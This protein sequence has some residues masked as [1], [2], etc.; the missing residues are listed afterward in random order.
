MNA[1]PF[2]SLHVC[3]TLSVVSRCLPLSAGSLKTQLISVRTT[4]F[5]L[6]VCK[7]RCPFLWLPMTTQVKWI[8][9]EGNKYG[10]IWPWQIQLK[11]RKVCRIWKS[12]FLV[13]LCFLIWHVRHRISFGSGYCPLYP[14]KTAFISKD[15]TI[16]V[17][18]LFV[19]D[20]FCLCASDSKVG[21]VCGKSIINTAQKLSKNY[22]K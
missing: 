7:L 14:T 3:M 17:Q 12:T 10:P 6:K 2:S 18:Y 11:L 5:L 21:D 16:Y 20:C 4:L 9:A 13:L 8:Y 1:I 22:E 19:S 15:M